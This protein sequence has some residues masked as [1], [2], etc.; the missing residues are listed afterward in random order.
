MTIREFGDNMYQGDLT[1]STRIGILAF[2]V[3][4]VV[5]GNTT[6]EV[7]H[8]NLDGPGEN[9]NPSTRKNKNDS[10]KANICK[11]TLRYGYTCKHAL[12]SNSAYLNPLKDDLVK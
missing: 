3:F 8:I 9:L 1:S 6:K 7:F 5:D 10:A 11:W 2:K 4:F 12:S